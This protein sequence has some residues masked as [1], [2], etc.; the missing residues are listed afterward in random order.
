MYLEIIDTGDSLKIHFGPLKYAFCGCQSSSIKYESI[1]QVNVLCENERPNCCY[2]RCNKCDCNDPKSCKKRVSF[3]ETIGLHFGTST[4]Y[5]GLSQW[6]FNPLECNVNQCKTNCFR[7]NTRST[8]EI[9][10]EQKHC[11][12]KRI[13]VTTDDAK[14]L[15]ELLESKMVKVNDKGRIPSQSIELQTK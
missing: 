1:H 4:K 5:Y 12:Y 2:C 13:V 6:L 8:F 10:I 7:L 14:G 3:E 9:I 15:I 11:F